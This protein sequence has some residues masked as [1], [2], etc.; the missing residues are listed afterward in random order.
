MEENLEK[1]KSKKTFFRDKKNI[2]IIVLSL[3]LLISI[4]TTTNKNNISERVGANIASI[5]E[6]KKHT[7]QEDKKRIE[8]LENE[9]KRLIE[10]KQNLED[11]KNR[12]QEEKKN[13]EAEK[14]IL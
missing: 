9:N 10:E 11:E 5:L 2:A 7:T 1:T 8:E 12:L 14:V 3:L 4:G 6:D 13:L